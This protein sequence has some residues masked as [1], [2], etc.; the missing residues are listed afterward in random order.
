MRLFIS[1]AREDLARVRELADLLED[2]GHQPWFDDKLVP[3][4]PWADQLVEEI[5]QSEVFVYAMSPVSVSSD[6][7]QKEYQVAVEL[8]KPILPVLLEA[9][10]EVPTSLASFQYADFTRGAT[11]RDTARLIGGIPRLLAFPRQVPEAPV[12]PRGVP[13][14]VL[15]L[16]REPAAEAPATPS[17]DLSGELVSPKDTEDLLAEAYAVRESNPER[18]LLLFYQLQKM[19]SEFMGPKTAEFIA[20]Q[21]ALLKPIRLANMQEQANALVEAREWAE[22]ERV[23]RAMMTLEPARVAFLRLVLN[24]WID[25]LLVGHDWDAADAVG[26]RLRQ[27]GG[28]DDT[29]QLVRVRQTA[30]RALAA[31]S[32][33]DRSLEFAQ[34]A[35]DLSPRGPDIRYEVLQRWGDASM[36]EGN[37]KQTEQVGEK[38]LALRRHDTFAQ[39]LIEK[40]RNN[41]LYERQYRQAAD[42]LRNGRNSAAFAL[43]KDLKAACPTYGDPDGLLTGRPIDLEFALWIRRQRAER[44][45][46]GIQTITFSPTGSSIWIGIAGKLLSLRVGDLE[47]EQLDS[48]KEEE[49][50]QGLNAF[51]L[52]YSASRNLRASASGKVITLERAD[53]GER[54]G[55]LAGHKDI[56]GCLAFSRD[57]SLLASNAY[58]KSIWLWDTTSQRLVDRV[59]G[60]KGEWFNILTFSPADDVLAAAG[61]DGIATWKRIGNSTSFSATHRLLTDPQATSLDISPNGQL[62]VSGGKGGSISL[63]DLT[64]S[65]LVI[66]LPTQTAEVAS[67]A[68]SPDGMLLGSATV[69]G[70]LTLWGMGNLAR[71][72]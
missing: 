68:F 54:L 25:A 26:L 19:D 22:A 57:G 7:C 23:A 30:A 31:D 12:E 49:I 37:W 4:L 59:T 13:T 46:Q 21:E 27:I 35:A 44:L 2:A 6:W 71:R 41:A 70:T 45:E 56:V 53:S 34:R 42:L 1:F 72:K 67:V 10:T 33:W 61:Y 63:W 18:A 55:T 28:A 52:Q 17:P 40:A 69:D 58:S 48:A 43:L 9:G 32:S 51:R 62:L 14:R 64:S 36:I 65:K 39:Q 29:R 50:R 8:H 47:P 38:M 20:Q 60:R 11:P 16:D 3:G 24:S 66:A 5:R 15:N